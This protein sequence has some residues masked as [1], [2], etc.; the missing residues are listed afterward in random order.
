MCLAEWIKPQSMKVYLAGIRALH[1]SHDNTIYWAA[2][3]TAHFLLLSASG[4]TVIDA[5]PYGTEASL[6][7]QDV[8]I[9]TTQA[10]EE[11]LSLHIRKYGNREQA[12]P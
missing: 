11:Y 5:P 6:C 8:D 4:F 7:I 3:T 12:A 10:C 9:Q 1:I 2:M